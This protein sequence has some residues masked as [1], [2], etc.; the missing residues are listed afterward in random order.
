[1]QGLMMSIHAEKRLNQRGIRDDDIDFIIASA[2]QV[3]PDAYI[4][5]R[6][7]ASREIARYK[8]RI[9]Q[10]ERLKGCKLVVEDGVIVTCMHARKSEQKRT[11]RK[12]KECK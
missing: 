12:G 8:R 7:D 5:T 2:S 1:M 6:E 9:Q 4:V 11:M 10:I 3:A